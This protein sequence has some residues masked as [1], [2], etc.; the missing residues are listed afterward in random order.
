MDEI[1][2]R[3]VQVFV[4]EA[5]G[6]QRLA[7]SLVIGAIFVGILIMRARIY[8]PV[9]CLMALLPV[10]AGHLWFSWNASEHRRFHSDHL[11]ALWAGCQD[12]LLRFREV[13]KRAKTTP[14]ADLREMPQTI[15]TVSLSVYHALRKADIVAHEI[16]ASEAGLTPLPRSN[17][18]LGPDEQ[19]QEL[20]QVADRNL[21][22]YKQGLEAV[23]A[24]VQRSEAQAAVFMTT[25]D[26][27]RVKILGYRL[28]GRGPELPSHE[29]LAAIAEAKL[30][31]ESIDKALDELDLSVY[32][33][34]VAV[35]RSTPP[36]LPVDNER[37]NLE[38]RG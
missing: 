8:F 32:P 22:E 9:A 33:Q 7:G 28:V 26:T 27:L 24:G 29:F 34:T 35:V 25:L 21:T 1:R 20:Y 6:I 10:T 11:K 38:G 17:R 4:A 2:R 36:P 3:D 37:Q 5:V 14:M 31:L 19:A 23:M 16:A 12:R 30:Q 13:Y 18:P 15:E